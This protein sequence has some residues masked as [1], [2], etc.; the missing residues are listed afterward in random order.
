LSGFL[1]LFLAASCVK[2]GPMGPAGED[3]IDGIDGWMEW[4]VMLPVLHVIQCNSIDT[5]QAQFAMSV[6]R[7]GMNAVDYAGEVVLPVQNAIH[8][9]DLCSC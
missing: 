4:T 9:K 2:E 1:F 7:A 5:I 8:T 3:G 6:H